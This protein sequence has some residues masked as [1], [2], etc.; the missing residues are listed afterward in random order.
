MKTVAITSL[1]VAGA[2]LTLGVIAISWMAYRGRWPIFGGVGSQTNASDAV[3]DIEL[4]A[5]PATEEVVDAGVE[6][7]F[8]ASDPIA[9]GSAHEAAK[10]RERRGQ[11]DLGDG[12]AEERPVREPPNWLTTH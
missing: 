8:P 5:R 10:E 7:T 1:A 9:V 6:E 4:R 12:G 3:S 2:A 11:F